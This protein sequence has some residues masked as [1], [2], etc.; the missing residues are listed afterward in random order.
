M[1]YDKSNIF[2]T[3]CDIIYTIC[4]KIKPYISRGVNEI[5]SEHM[6]D[7]EPKKVATYM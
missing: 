7:C 4:M 2:A 1:K 3:P 5:L 6:S